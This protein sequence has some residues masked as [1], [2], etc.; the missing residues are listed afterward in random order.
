MSESTPWGYVLVHVPF[1]MGLRARGPNTTLRSFF[2]YFLPFHCGYII[3]FR[4]IYFYVI[5]LHVDF[6][7]FVWFWFVVVL[8]EYL[9]H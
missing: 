3:H 5:F 2:R 9:K 7:V 4:L 1:V 8:F 6:S